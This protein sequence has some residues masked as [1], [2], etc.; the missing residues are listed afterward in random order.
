M[1]QVIP[2]PNIWQT[3]EV[4]EIENAG[5]DRAGLIDATM[6]R[7]HPW[8]DADVVDI[9]CGSGYHLPRLAARARSVV[10]IEPHPPLVALARRR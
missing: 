8:D 2:A 10:G 6:Q 7:I 3:P 9:G 4:Y 5:I 1:S